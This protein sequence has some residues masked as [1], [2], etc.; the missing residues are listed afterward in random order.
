MRQIIC[1][2]GDSITWGACDIEKGGWVAR[3]R[4]YLENNNFNVWVYNCGVSGANTDKLLKRFKVE[5]LARR[6]NLIIFAIGIN[7]S[8]YVNSKDNPRVPL[9]KFQ[10]NLQELINQAKEFT[11]Q[12]V[13]V[14]LTKVDES[15]TMPIPWDP[16]KFYDRENIKLYNAKIKEVCEKNNL[17]FIEMFDLLNDSDLEDGLHPNSQGHEKMFLRIKDFLLSNNL[18]QET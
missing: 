6:P 14:G 1:A 2:F 9:E 4:G 8:Q 13:F 5:A 3:L 18:I 11:D 7:D 17:L 16:I 15:K 12:I 10:K